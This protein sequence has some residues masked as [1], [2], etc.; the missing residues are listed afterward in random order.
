MCIRDRFEEIIF[1]LGVYVRTKNSL[2]PYLS[3]ISFKYLRS[4]SPSIRR[5]SE[6]ASSLKFFALYPKLTKKI[7]KN[8][9]VIFGFFITIFLYKSEKITYVRYSLKEENLKLFNFA[10][11]W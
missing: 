8:N 2:A 6:E 3:V 9:R 5:V 4:G 10:L 11:F 1:S 7:I